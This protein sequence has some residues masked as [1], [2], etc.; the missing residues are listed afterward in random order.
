MSRRPNHVELDGPV[1]ITRVH[2]ADIPPADD[3]L[4]L[5]GHAADLGVI[6]NLGAGHVTAVAWT[7]ADLAGR[8]RPSAA[9][10][11]QALAFWTGADR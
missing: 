10:C 4:A 3:G 2:Q 11:A 1:R 8:P 7:L 6:G 5:I 9:E